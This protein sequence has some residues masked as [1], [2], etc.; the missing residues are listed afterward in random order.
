VKA[1]RNYGR[2]YG[3]ALLSE[4]VTTAKRE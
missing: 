1:V 4:R 3:R 2:Y